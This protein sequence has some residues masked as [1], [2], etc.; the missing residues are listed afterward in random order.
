MITEKEAR[1]RIARWTSGFGGCH[2]KI[3]TI[4]GTK[5]LFRE[6][7]LFYD[8]FHSD[9]RIEAVV[10]DTFIFPEKDAK[11]DEPSILSQFRD[12]EP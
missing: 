10:V 9:N 4:P 2:E 3:I 11:Q 7:K 12:C 8:V 5:I 1:A 6:A